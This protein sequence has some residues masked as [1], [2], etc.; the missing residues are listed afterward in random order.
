VSGYRVPENERDIHSYHGVGRSADVF[1]EGVPN[2]TIFDWCRAQENLGCGYYP[3][4][5]HVHIDVRSRAGV[6]VDLSRD[7]EAAQYVPNA[8][9]WLRD[10]VE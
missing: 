7:R 9:G 8:A 2:R 6:W 4:A 10:H 1:L 5:T 3:R